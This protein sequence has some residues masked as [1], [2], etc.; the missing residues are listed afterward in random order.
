MSYL[1]PLLWQLVPSEFKNLNTAFKAAFKNLKLNTPHV[2]CLKDILEML[3]L[4]KL[5]VWG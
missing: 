3:D 1:R 5:L 4:F 2:G